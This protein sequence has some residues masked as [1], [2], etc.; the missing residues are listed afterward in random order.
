M[1]HVL[2]LVVG[3]LSTLVD[4]LLEKC[5]VSGLFNMYGEMVPQ[6]FSLIPE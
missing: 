4:E 1:Y 2:K 3:T 5:A 6:F